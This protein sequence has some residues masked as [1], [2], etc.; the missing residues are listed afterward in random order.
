MNRFTQDDILSSL[1]FRTAPR[2]T[3]LTD[4]I[5]PAL[6]VFGTGLLVGAGAALLLAPKSGRELRS[7]IGTGA[8]H[9]A[10]NIGTS[11]ASFRDTVSDRMPALPNFGKSDA[12]TRETMATAPSPAPVGSYES[13]MV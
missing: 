5:L 13:G 12:T 1:G 9:L 7:D 4:T 2:S 8:A 11:A 6:A 10:D 3:E